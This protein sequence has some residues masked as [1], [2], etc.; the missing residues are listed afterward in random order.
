MKITNTTK[1][2]LGLSFETIVPAGG[3]LDIDAGAFE[4][5]A[6]IPVVRSWVEDGK[7]VPEAPAAETAVKQTRRR[8]AK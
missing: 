3:F 7:L 8:K 2:D 4:A 5:F 1:G 6:A